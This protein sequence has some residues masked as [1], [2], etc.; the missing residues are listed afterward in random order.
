MRELVRPVHVG[1][2][3]YVLPDK[4]KKCCLTWRAAVDLHLGATGKR[5]TWSSH[6]IECKICHR[7]ST[8]EREFEEHYAAHHVDMSIYNQTLRRFKQWNTAG[9][10]ETE[11]EYNVN[12]IYTIGQTLDIQDMTIENDILTAS[13]LSAVQKQQQRP[14]LASSG[15]TNRPKEPPRSVAA[16]TMAPETPTNMTPRLASL[17]EK[18]R[19]AMIQKDSADDKKKADP[20][21]HAQDVNKDNKRAKRDADEKKKKK[22]KKKKR[23]RLLRRHQLST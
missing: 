6:F 22:K 10:P 16:S 17:L 8:S 1:S 7:F 4:A 18:G 15:S 19:A 11:V 21:V 14:V 2:L 9:V 5:P 3:A 20:K 12:L 23:R 13:G